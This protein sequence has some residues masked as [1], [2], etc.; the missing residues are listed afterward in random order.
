[1]FGQ[2]EARAIGPAVMGGRI[3]SIEGVEK[4]ARTIYVGTA[5]GGIWKSTTGGSLFKPVF[6]KYAQ[7]IGALAID[8]KNP[9]TIYAGT[10][11]SNMRNS[12]GIGNGLYKTTDAGESWVLVGLD[13]TEHISKIAIDPANSNV[14]YVAAPGALWSDSPHRGLYKTTDGGKTWE[15]ILYKD[16]GTGCADVM[17]DP[18]NTNIVYASMWKFRRTAWSFASGGESSGLFKSTDGGKTWRKIQKGFDG[19]MLGRICL[20]MA[21]SAPDNLYAIAEAKETALYRS[22]DAGETWVKQSNNQNVS[23]R[24]FYFSCMVVDPTDSNRIYRPSLTLSYSNDG[25]QSFSQSSFDGGWVH[26]DHH[27]LWINP[28]N[29]SQLFLGTDGGVYMSM[30][31]G[32]NFIF[33]NSL[34]LSQFYH[35][36]IDEQVPYNVYGG[37]QDNGSWMGPSQSP[38]GIENKDWENVGGGDGFWVQPD[39]LDPSYVY[40][41]S[42]GGNIIRFCK[43]NNEYKDIQPYPKSGEP[44][45]RWNWNTPLYASPNDK[46]VLYCGSQFL[47]KTRDR[48]NSWE[49]ISPDLTTNNPAKQKQEESGGITVDN[50]SAENHCTI[51]TI[52]ESPLDNNTIY[53]GTDDGNLQVTTDGGKSW[54]NL[55]ANIK[56]VPANTWCSS[57]EASKHDKNV[58]YASFENH[59]RGDFI[60]YIVKTTDGGN[61]WSNI[62]TTDIKSFVHKI[63]EDPLNKNIL[64]AGTE[65]GLYITLDGGTTWTQFTGKV[66]MTPVRDIVIDK[67]SND[68]ILATH[69]RGILIIDDLTPIRS[70]TPEL[71]EKE[72]AL[73]PTRPNYLSMGQYGSGFPGAGGYTGDNSTEE[74]VIYYYLKERVMSGDVRVEIYDREGKLLEKIPGSKRKGLNR[75]TWGM[76]TK[77]PRTAKGVRLDFGGFMGPM[78]TKGMY[79]IKLIKGD[80]SYD[81]TIELMPL[82]NSPYTEEERALASSTTL[83]LYAMCEELAYMNHQVICI[84]DTAKARMAASSDKKDLQKSLKDLIDRMEKQR[85]LYVATTAGTAITGEERIREKLSNLYGTVCNQEGKPTASQLD[86]TEGLRKEMDDAMATATGYFNNELKKANTLLAKHKLPSINPPTRNEFDAIK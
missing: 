14:V 81:G 70:L 35:V 83:R 58:I 17:V 29:P 23:W 67:K 31:R 33:L 56:V 11:E 26:S 48:G 85:G 6:E 86:R 20:A 39:L 27:A 62:A 7:S 24:P 8:Q 75:V 49:R 4:D 40:S 53:V 54:K 21:P 64:L 19:Q 37:L 78:V 28:K 55:T 52:C 30:D 25:G 43:K 50:S 22:T 16:A 9:K 12:V 68:V 1:M 84:A 41:E 46:S 79:N 71:L 45:L 82:P 77:P 42:Q 65:M 59:T 38:N 3:T 2:Y 76:R 63:K 61:T 36:A 74:A 80:K 15:K 73:L 10:G 13:S 47:Y 69:G 18:R 51:F 44:K 34:P 32:V 5:A 60:A 66:P 72:V 57:I